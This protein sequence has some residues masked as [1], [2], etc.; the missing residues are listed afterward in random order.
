MFFRYGVIAVAV[1]LAGCGG[2]QG[3]Q[4]SDA[5]PQGQQLSPS[6]LRSTSKASNGRFTLFAAPGNTLG[7]GASNLIV[8]SDGNFWYAE[9]ASDGT[10]TIVR[11]TPAGVATS[12]RIPNNDRGAA[13]TPTS[14]AAG[15][16]GKVWFGSEQ[17]TIGSVTTSGAFAE[18]PV[19]RGAG[20]SISVGAASAS[21][22]VW[23][24]NSDQS[25]PGASVGYIGTGGAV[26]QFALPSG[27]QFASPATVALGP[28]GNFWFATYDTGIGRVTAGGRMNF[29][30][31]PSISSPGY[32]IAGPGGTIWF[33]GDSAVGELSVTGALIARYDVPGVAYLT[34]DSGGNVWAGEG[35]TCCGVTLDE[36]A[37]S[38]TVT[39]FAA[40]GNRDYVAQGLAVGLDGNIWFTTAARRGTND[41]KGMG[42]F[43]L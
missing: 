12:Y 35:G 11:Y 5:G 17:C 16:D 21:T 31:V 42:T 8:G 22:G 23:F 13:I 14:V 29:Y 18:Y 2:Q 38:G 3:L 7:A 33:A 10:G 6:G 20:C 25:E 26:R 19:G 1:A 15:P 41:K 32:V 30:P 43:V 28:D 40:P 27:Y 39:R 36:I 4:P 37:A 34:A 9:T 24:T